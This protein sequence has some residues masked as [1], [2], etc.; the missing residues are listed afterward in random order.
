MKVSNAMKS[1]FEVINYIYMLF[2]ICIYV[3]YII[4]AFTYA[5]ELGMI[6]FVF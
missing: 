6:L 4:C 1:C 3:I 2:I 5:V